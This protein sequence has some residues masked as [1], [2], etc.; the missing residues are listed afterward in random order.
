[1]HIAPAC[2]QFI[3]PLDRPISLADGDVWISEYAFEA[4]REFAAAC[5]H[6]CLAGFGIP[7]S[8]LDPPDEPALRRHRVEEDEPSVT[9][10]AGS[11]DQL[12]GPSDGLV[13]FYAEAEECRVGGDG[14]GIIEVGV[15]GGPPKRVAQIGQVGGEPLVRLTL[16]GAIPQRQ[17]VGFLCSEVTGM[18]AAKLI[19]LTTGHNLF[20]GELADGLEHRKPGPRRRTVGDD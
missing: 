2:E 11:F 20:L 17:N 18:R 9:G 5:A 6:R 15:V 12:F 19:S 10:G 13:V 4:E 3:A 8:F 16:A 14:G 7:E 1:V